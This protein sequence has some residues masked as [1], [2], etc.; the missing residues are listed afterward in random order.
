MYGY[1]DIKP[2]FLHHVAGAVSFINTIVHSKTNFQISL[3]I[4]EEDR[5]IP[6]I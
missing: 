5:Q 1:L 2:A 4:F 3:R 6:A